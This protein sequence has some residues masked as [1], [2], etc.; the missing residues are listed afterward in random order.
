MPTIRDLD[1]AVEAHDLNQH[2]FYQAW[3]AGTLPTETLA[4]YAAEYG[5]FIGTI[6]DGWNTLGNSEHAKEER[7][8]AELW[9]NGFKAAL[10][11]KNDPC[12]EVDALVSEAKKNFGSRAA[13]IG[14]LYAFEAQQPATA[15]SKLE[16]LREHYDVGEAGEA[17]FVL[18]ANDY[19]EKTMLASEMQKLSDDDR[20]IALEACER[21][22]VAM[23]NALSGIYPQSC[24]GAMPA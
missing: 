19:G 17:Y 24:D 8:H 15:H 1:L 16:G 11:A 18:H 9:E 20:A 22:C 23:W 5:R 2:P 7:R 4:R 10:A 6:A 3:R 14:A 21:T 13:A 12:A